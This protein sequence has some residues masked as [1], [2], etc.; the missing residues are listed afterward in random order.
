MIT[1]TIIQNLITS[2]SVDVGR[3][4]GVVRAGT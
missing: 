3:K 4:G 2:T 1:N